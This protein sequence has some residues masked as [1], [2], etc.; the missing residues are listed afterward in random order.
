MTCPS[1]TVIYKTKVK[2]LIFR[3]TTLAYHR[4]I[5]FTDFFSQSQ[6]ETP[7]GE[8]TTDSYKIP[9]GDTLAV[10]PAIISLSSD[11]YKIITIDQFIQIGTDVYTPLLHQNCMSP[12]QKT[13]YPLTIEQHDSDRITLSDHYHSIILELNNLPDLQ[14]KPWYPVI[15]KKSCIPCTNCGRCSW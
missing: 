14:V 3:L 11:D 2:S 15:K 12:D 1:T 7:I 6:L 9:A 4:R 5:L 8:F 10:S 13:I